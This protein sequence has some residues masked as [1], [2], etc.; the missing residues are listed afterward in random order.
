MRVRAPLAYDVGMNNGDDCEYYLKKGYQVVAIEANSELC[1]LASL[2]FAREISEGKLS[3]LNI[4]VGSEV[5]R[6]PFYVHRT[7]SVL[8][9][10]LPRSQRT[11]Y[12]AEVGS[13]EFDVV[14][15][16]V[17]R[18]S[19]VVAF[20]GAP[21]YIKIDVEGFDSVCLRDL[22]L[23]GIRPNYLSAEAHTV[24]TFCHLIT[25]GYHEFKMVS[26]GMVA[27][28]FAQHEITLLDGGTVQFQFKHHSAG[29]F[30]ED[31]P[32]NWVGPNDILEQWLKRGS[33]W[34]DLHVRRSPDT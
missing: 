12:T 16:E 5:G 26:G 28:D 20:F 17:R 25:M 23:R 14:P 31:I 29:P 30:G 24:E 21:D 34:F 33:G 18:L 22:D 1:K 3:I 4:G 11:G 13:E 32:G 19:D 10:F 7:N 2:R 6:L 15:V 27:T 8:S 9:T